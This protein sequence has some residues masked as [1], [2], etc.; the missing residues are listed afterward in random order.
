MLDPEKLKQETQT[1]DTDKYMKSQSKTLHV[2]AEVTQGFSPSSCYLFACAV[3]ND[4]E[5]VRL[6]LREE[7]LSVKTCLTRY[8]HTSVDDCWQPDK[9][10]LW[11]TF[12]SQ[13]KRLS[14]GIWRENIKEL[15]ERFVGLSFTTHNSK[16][17]YPLTSNSFVKIGY[18]LATDTDSKHEL[19]VCVCVC[20]C[21][22]VPVRTHARVCLRLCVRKRA[23]NWIWHTKAKIA[24]RWGN[25]CEESDIMHG[26]TH[27]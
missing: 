9:R 5:V 4:A 15:K 22:C 26:N 23:I 1:D 3:I 10:I 12:F 21:A 2:W 8:R 19:Y 16:I 13:D 11:L 24:E 25:V 17:F 6:W 20:I 7:G 14:Y 27:W 18:V